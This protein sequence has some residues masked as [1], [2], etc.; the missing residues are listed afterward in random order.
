MYDRGPRDANAFVKSVNM[1]GYVIFLREFAVRKT[2]G[3]DYE[4]F[5]HA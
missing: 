1:R 2:V 5:D 4:A 3:L